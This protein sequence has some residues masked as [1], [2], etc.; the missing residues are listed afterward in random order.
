MV[1]GVMLTLRAHRWRG[2]CAQQWGV[3]GQP[4]KHVLQHLK[5]GGSAADTNIIN[6]RCAIVAVACCCACCVCMRAIQQC[7]L[8]NGKVLSEP[9]AMSTSSRVT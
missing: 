1:A 9:F 2:D 5:V 7:A 6:N 3:I 8:P 4:L